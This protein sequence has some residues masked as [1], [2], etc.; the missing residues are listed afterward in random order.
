M[1]TRRQLL[2]AMGAT[3]APRAVRAQSDI[4]ALIN[5]AYVYG[6]P[7]YEI[8]RLRWQ[9]QYDPAL[10]LHLPSNVIFHRRFLSNATSR[11][12]TAPNNDTLYSLAFLDLRAGPLRI[13]VPDMADR[14]YSIAFVD[15]Y[16]N[17]F[18]YIG[19]RAT[20]TRAGS[21]AIVGP[22]ASASATGAPVIQAPTPTG[23]LIV[24]ILTRG[25]DELDAV[26]RLQDA[27]VLTPRGLP[28]AQPPPPAPVADSGEGFVAV[29]NRALTDNPPPAA[30]APT[31]AHLA[32]V[33]IGPSAPPLDGDARRAWN[34]RFVEVQ[35]S[36]ANAAARATRLING[37]AYPPNDVGRFGTDYATRANVALTFLLEN[38][39]EEAMSIDPMADSA[40]APLDDRH[41]YR[42]R[43]PARMPV[44]GFW[45]LTMY[46]REPD[47]RRFFFDNP[48][49]RY[50]IGDRTP[51][52]RRNGD[53][54]LDIIL[55]RERPAPEWEN[56][57]LPMPVGPY[58]VTLRN[59][60]PRPELLDGTFRYA[61]VEH[62]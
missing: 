9:A 49:Q 34:E 20:G 3:L 42:V 18:G 59:Y 51:N 24:R 5:A 8:A 26:H 4:G 7:V 38:V 22:G 56:N 35:R 44:D 27:I 43:L 61:A 53:G 62:I 16:T 46:R 30:D 55:A 57:W 36:L 60:Q 52:L 32:T 6:L 28:P 47:G 11:E 10:P 13:E 37:W 29:V 14:Y 25:A 45:S 39:R 1:K 33:G 17:D 21:F 41:A 58:S 2:A 12:V 40:G 50:A 19:R 23:V 31:L 15:A 48:L 54:S